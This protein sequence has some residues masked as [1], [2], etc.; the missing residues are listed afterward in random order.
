MRQQHYIKNKN[1][2]S[3]M[4]Q[5][6]LLNNINNNDHDQSNFCWAHMHKTVYTN[7]IRCICY[8]SVLIKRFCWTVTAAGRGCEERQGCRIQLNQCFCGSGC[9]T[10]YIYANKE[11]CRA[12]LKGDKSFSSIWQLLQTEAK[13]LQ[14]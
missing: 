12:A 1:C 5:F 13:T 6:Y 3:T 7:S 2:L 9:V 4:F 8:F 11:D 14:F 10:D